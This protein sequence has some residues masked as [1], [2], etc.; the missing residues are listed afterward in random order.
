MQGQD[1]SKETQAN[2]G[3]ERETESER[4][5]SLQREIDALKGALESAESRAAELEKRVLMVPV[6]TDDE[7]RASDDEHA[8]GLCCS[9]Y[10]GLV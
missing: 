2:V 4:I 6:E 7:V 5:A 9:V 8:C 3:V 10:Q 1:Q